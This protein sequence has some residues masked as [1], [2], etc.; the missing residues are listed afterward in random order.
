MLDKLPS[1][2]VGKEVLGRY[3]EKL[4]GKIQSLRI[5]DKSDGNKSPGRNI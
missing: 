2:V 3:I 4:W 5:E 1:N